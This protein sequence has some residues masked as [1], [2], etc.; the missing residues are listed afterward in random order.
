MPTSQSRWR[1]ESIL[2][3]TVV[4]ASPVA[5][6]WYRGANTD[7]WRLT[8]PIGDW[9]R[10]GYR[11]ALYTD[12]VSGINQGF[13]TL[14]TTSSTAED[15]LLTS[16]S[17]ATSTSTLV[18]GVSAEVTKSVSAQ[19]NFNMLFSTSTAGITNIDYYTAATTAIIYAELAYL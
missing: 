3:A 17:Y 18:T 2:K 6:T 8:L 5:S 11:A 16:T 7:S 12:R 15:S 14:S 9:S 19:T 1:L 10:F 4:V 13:C